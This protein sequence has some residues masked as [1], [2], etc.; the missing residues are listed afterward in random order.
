MVASHL[1]PFIGRQRELAEITALLA[2]PACRLLTLVG[3][4]GIGK[5]RLAIEVVNPSLNPSPSH[6]EGLESHF[7]NG[8]HFVPLQPVADAA[9]LPIAIANAIGIQ[10]FGADEPRVQL[11]G[12]LQNRQML[13]IL[14]NF[15]HLL[16][17]VDF[18]VEMLA[19]PGVRLLVTSRAALNIQAEWRYAV[20]GLSVP[21]SKPLAQGERGWGEGLEHYDAVRLFTERARRLRHDFSPD[22]HH[23]DLIRICQLT[24]GMPL[25]LELAAGWLKALSCAQIADEIQ[26]GLDFLAADARDVPERHRSMTAAFAQSWNLL[27][28]DEQKIFRRMSV[29]RG[30]F[31]REAAEKV[32]GA[33][34]Q[35]LASLADKSFLRIDAAGRYDVHELLRQY[36]EAKLDAAGEVE[37]IHDAHSAYY[38]DF[39]AQRDADVKGRRQVAALDEIEADFENIRAAWYRAVANRADTA[40]GRALEALT[41]YCNWRNRF[42][43]HEELYTH[44]HE[45]FAPLSGEK[46]LL[47]WAQLMVRRAA[48]LASYDRSDDTLFRSFYEISLGVIS[49]YDDPFETAFTAFRWGNF[50]ASTLEDD[51]LSYLEQALEIFQT[52]EDEFYISEC[53]FWIAWRCRD[54]NQMAE[55]FHY[56]QRC[57]ELKLRIG[58]KSDAAWAIFHLSISHYQTGNFA[59]SDKHCHHA[60]GLFR[61]VG[62]Y[63][64]ISATI[65]L[66]GLRTY[67]K[68][69]LNEALDFIKQASSYTI[70]LKSHNVDFSA[71]LA[72][73]N[74]IL[75]E[76]Y[77]ESLEQ[78]KNIP[79]TLSRF[80]DL[81][82]MMALCGLEQYEQA[83]YL[84]VSVFVRKGEQFNSHNITSYLTIAAIIFANQ[85]EQEHAVEVFGLIF[86]QPV[87]WIGWVKRWGLV[88]RLL[89]RLQADLGDQVY[90]AAW[91]RG[92]NLNLETTFAEIVAEFGVGQDAPDQKRL[93]SLT[94]RERE[95]L[96]LVA[97]GLSNRQIARD[98]ILSLGTVKAYIHTIYSKIGVESRT[99]AVARARELRLL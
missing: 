49:L 96:R 41:W 67:W 12:Y 44:A 77:A 6:G 27:T 40:I 4:G 51:A 7:A 37:A 90:A 16:D 21:E 47:I 14:D 64:G 94:P 58:D 17:G 97:A 26:R 35:I 33:T 39:L 9:L 79:K 89:D 57:A 84:L 83:Q 62:N 3:P 42:F 13:L 52:L 25:A 76:D 8:G 78:A 69:D 30:G 59:A 32:T 61:E 50:L 63:L 80:V 65:R 88:T 95:V 45:Q 28:G 19:A 5:T 66:V 86:S 2:D 81:L 54:L 36:G 46:P 55:F 99:Q 29:F 68:G 75:R 91:G 87:E 31:T 20:G 71:D 24:E 72:H 10:F 70:N 48:N 85:G 22:D 43:E 56:M 34:L 53:W 93:D 15:E 98:L 73:I 23:A 74:C 60:Q 82:E 1:T 92:Q 11:L 38:L 18:V